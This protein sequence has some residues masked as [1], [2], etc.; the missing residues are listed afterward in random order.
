V[1]AGEQAWYVDCRR[2]IDRGGSGYAVLG[3]RQ[4]TADGVSGDP[5]GENQM[6]YVMT[7]MIWT[8]AEARS[9]PSADGG[10]AND[11]EGE[12]SNMSVRSR[13]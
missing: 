4:M 11:N 1:V 7:G 5:R 10:S 9:L 8:P 6:T 13:S 12:G 3:G 2:R